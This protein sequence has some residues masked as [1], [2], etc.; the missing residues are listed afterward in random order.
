[1]LT[2]L[3]GIIPTLLGI[4]SSTIPNLVQ[5][6]ERGQTFKHEK[7]LI[8]LRME[9]TARG[10]DQ[11]ELIAGAKADVAEGISLREHDIA[12]TDNWFINLVRAA[13]RPFLTIFFFLLWAGTK[14]VIAK[15]MIDNNIAAEKIIEVVWDPVSVSI[16]GA[17]MGFWF[18]TRTLLHMSGKV[19]PQNKV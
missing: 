5:Y 15:M 10:L 16:F 18:G 19:T 14:I 12:L 2:I 13:I 9:A 11:Q 1:M 3:A 6:L 8:E 7:E 4:L 17:I